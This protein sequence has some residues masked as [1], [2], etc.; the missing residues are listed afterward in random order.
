M[1]NMRT[2][3]N[4]F[5]HKQWYKSDTTHGPGK[6]LQMDSTTTIPYYKVLDSQH[7]A[8]TAGKVWDEPRQQSS[9]VDSA[10][11][12]SGI[13]VPSGPSETEPETAVRKS[14]RALFLELT[15]K[16]LSGTSHIVPPN[17]DE[18]DQPVDIRV[19]MTVK[20]I[21]KLDTRAQTISLKAWVEVSWQS[22]WASWDTDVYPFKH[23]FL[24]ASKVWRPS[25]AIYNS[26]L[27]SDQFMKMDRDIKVGAGGLFRWFPG[28]IFDVTCKVNITLYPFDTQTCNL[29]LGLWSMSV[30]DANGTEAQIDHIFRNDGQWEVVK[31]SARRTLARNVVGN[32]FWYLDF[33]LTL[34]RKWLFYALNVVMPVAWCPRSI[35]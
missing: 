28:G 3:W 16:L 29:Q 21:L 12:S 11:T 34:K 31:V 26:L 27:P 4:G 13:P 10:T 22:S 2:P 33:T 6:V 35:A 17:V 8:S 14:K 25:L 20:D 5:W 7:E 24:Q 32:T 30:E 9:A 19:A 18:P 1:C 15:D 23:V